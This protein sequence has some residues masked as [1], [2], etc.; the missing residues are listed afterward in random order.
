MHIKYS[1]MKIFFEMALVH[2]TGD[3][4]QNHLPKKKKQD[5]CW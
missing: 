5:F 4:V 3:W 1:T 2:T